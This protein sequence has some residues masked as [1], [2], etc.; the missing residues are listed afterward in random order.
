M[1]KIIRLVLN[2]KVRKNKYFL[3]PDMFAHV[4]CVS[5][6]KIFLF[7][8]RVQWVVPNMVDEMLEKLRF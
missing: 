8:G 5:G 7:F 3:P 6:S 4:V 2:A 1:K